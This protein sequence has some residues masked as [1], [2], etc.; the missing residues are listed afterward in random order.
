M[1]HPQDHL[2]LGALAMSSGEGRAL[3]APVRLD[4]LAFGGQTYSARGGDVQA[5]ID[6][7]RT[8]SGYSGRLRFQVA[9]SGPC[10]RCLE[11]ADRTVA[12]DAREIDQP[13]GDEETTSPYFEGTALDLRGWARDALALALPL[14]IICR[15]D[16]LGLCPVCGQ[17]LNHAE[18]GHAHA[19]APGAGVVEDLPQEDA[20]ARGSLL[21]EGHQEAARALD[22]SARHGRQHGERHHGE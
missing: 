13:G 14:Q 6:L 1:S 18:P 7:S 2:D 15:D 16:C 10:M 12:V 21:V 20:R 5:R 9:L 22:P 11:E 4:P 8:S 3:D 19:R 17:N